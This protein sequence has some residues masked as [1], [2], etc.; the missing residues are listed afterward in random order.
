MAKKKS[1]KYECGECGLVVIVDDPCS[2]TACELMC[3]GVPMKEVKRK[4]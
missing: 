4:K 2:C 1:D 3:C